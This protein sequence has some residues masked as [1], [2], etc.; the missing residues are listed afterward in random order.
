MI[1]ITL[2]MNLD[3]RLGVDGQGKELESPDE[4]GMKMIDCCVAIK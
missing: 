4:S 3:M 1:K 2:T